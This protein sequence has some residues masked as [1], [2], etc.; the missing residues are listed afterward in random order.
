[1]FDEAGTQ[2]II[3]RP[4]VK[5]KVLLA[6]AFGFCGAFLAISQPLSYETGVFLGV[7]ILALTA[8]LSALWS[9]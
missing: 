3:V 5:R 8:G 7:I 4:D 1:M 6:G 2:E 9:P